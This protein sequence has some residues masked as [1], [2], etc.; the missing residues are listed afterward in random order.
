MMEEKA[1]GYFEDGTRYVD[2]E[3]LYRNCLNPNWSEW[4]EVIDV[5]RSI[6]EKGS[7]S[8]V[9]PNSPIKHLL[10]FLNNYLVERKIV[11][12]SNLEWLKNDHDKLTEKKGDAVPDFVNKNGVTY[13]LK[14]GKNIEN[15][16]LIRNWYGA[17]RKLFYCTSDNNLYLY[18]SDKNSF[19]IIKRGLRAPY[20]NI[21]R[22]DNL[23]A[24]IM[25]NI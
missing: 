21:R 10:Q 8:Y 5:M 1:V 20:I 17:D 4:K 6:E 19:K 12:I 13:E 24:Q 15:A 9:Y 14:S 18:D 3:V 2:Y 11:D 16:A 23:E 25:K 22:F 7:K